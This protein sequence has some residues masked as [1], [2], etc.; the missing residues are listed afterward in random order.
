MLAYYAILAGF[1]MLVFTVSI[2]IAVVPDAALSDGISMAARA[3]PPSVAEVLRAQV[4]GLS[5]NTAAGF[6]IGAAAVSLFGAS[7]AAAALMG[8][9]NRLYGERE[10]RSFLRRQ[11]TAIVVTL[12]VAV[13]VV[14]ALALLVVGPAA[15]HWIADR[16]GLGAAFDVAWTIARWL[17]AG[18][19][20]TLVWAIAYRFLPNTRE[21]FRLFVPGAVVGVVLWLGVSRL[22]QLY[23][24]HWNSYAT[25]YGALGTG[26]I[27]LTWIWLTNIALLVGAEVNDI[28]VDRRS[29]R[30]MQQPRS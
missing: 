24:D 29:A 18:A 27:L 12:G 23:I 4:L 6:A 25:T 2:A 19:L 20:V 15:G 10:T 11:L 13:L 14:T 22:F 30:S 16:F 8:V 1:P 26:I 7:R 5:K 21:P 9:L 17:G 28:L 3:I